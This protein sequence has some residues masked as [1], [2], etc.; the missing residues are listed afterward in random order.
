[1]QG[2]VGDQPAG[3][4]SIGTNVIGF[5]VLV[6]GFLARPGLVKEEYRRIVIVLVQTVLDAA[7]FFDGLCDKILHVAFDDG[8]SVFVDGNF[9]Y[10]SEHFNLPNIFAIVI[11]LSTMD[12]A[13]PSSFG[14]ERSGIMLFVPW[15]SKITEGKKEKRYGQE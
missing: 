7:V 6:E 14:N 1:V 10:D 3:G 5:E 4:G 9:H 15:L 11:S 12:N 8:D 13:L 2:V